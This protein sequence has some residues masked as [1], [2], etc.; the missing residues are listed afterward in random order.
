MRTRRITQTID[1]LIDEGIAFAADF[2]DDSEAV[3]ARDGWY[4]EVEDA[5]RMILPDESALANRVRQVRDDPERTSLAVKDSL[6]ILRRA[7]ELALLKEVDEDS[8]SLDERIRLAVNEMSYRSRGIA[9]QV[10]LVAGTLMFAVTGAIRLWQDEVNF[11]EQVRMATENVETFSEKA[12]TKIGS[13]VADTQEELRKQVK[14]AKDIAGRLE[15]QTA[16]AEQRIATVEREI[17]GKVSNATG[18]IL[19]QLKTEKSTQIDDDLRQFVQ[20]ERKRIGNEVEKY[21]RGLKSE[22][23]PQVG[24][25]LGTS[26]IL[27]GELKN[28]TE[29]LDESVSTLEIQVSSLSTL[30]KN[31]NTR[32]SKHKQTLDQLW[33]EDTQK[34]VR[35]LVPVVERGERVFSWIVGSYVLSAVALI[36]I[37][38]I[39]VILWLRRPKKGRST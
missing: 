37:A 39:L 19:S 10:L 30:E 2:R 22:A 32:L 6:R 16:A 8:K 27:A 17:D 38:T 1:R 26:L 11:R 23:A 4:R 18:S 29:S 35:T 15:G 7:R 12:E 24:K 31:L 33:T 36:G 14:I 9:I 21:I 25:V 3:E 28:K 20:V 13:V 5:L 34:L